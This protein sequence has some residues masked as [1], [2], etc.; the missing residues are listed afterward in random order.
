MSDPIYS[1]DVSLAT[2]TKVPNQFPTVPTVSKVAIIGEAPGATEETEGLPFVGAS[3]RLLNSLLSLVGMSR[4]QCFVGN[5]CQIRPPGNDIKHFDWDGDEIQ[6]GLEQLRRDLMQFDP[7]LIIVMGNA[8]LRAAKGIKGEVISNWRGSMF[9][10]PTFGRKC[11]AAY[12]PAYVLRDWSAFPL[13]LFDLKRAAKESKSRN[14]VLP[15]RFIEV[16]L[17]YW[18]VVDRINRINSGELTS[19]DIEGG[20]DGWTLMG[21]APRPEYAFIVDW[22][23]Y[24]EPLHYKLVAQALSRMLWRLDIPKIL[25]NSLY[26]NFVLAYGY[27]MLIRNV[28]EDTM[29]GGWEIYCEL[30]K[31]LGT[32]A[33]IYTM[34]PYYKV[35]HSVKAKKE[36]MTN[37]DAAKEYRVYCGKDSCTT[38]EIQQRQAEILSGPALEH[39]RFNMDLLHPLLYM[40]LR[41]INYA[42]EKAELL[43]AETQIE[44]NEYS[45]RL[46][47]R[48][49]Y[50]LVGPKGSLVS[51][52]MAK[53]LYQERGYPAQYKKEKGRLTDK[54]T[55]DVEALLTLMKKFPED[56][57]I[58][59]ILKHRKLESRLE[60]L[61]IGTDPDG[62][63]RCAYN[64]V[65]TETGRITC[66]GSPTGS[67]ANL[68]TITKKLRIL[69][70]ADPGYWLFQ[71]DLSG[72]DG[73]T[74]AARLKQLG[75][76][77][78]WDDYTA[79]LKP[80][81][82]IALMYAKGAEINKLSREE[83][84]QL[85]KAVDG[86][87]W[88]YFACKVVQHGTSYGMGEQT[89]STNIMKL[90]Y[91]HM[92]Q[93]FYVEPSECR[94]I[95][96]YFLARY[97]G[98]PLWHRQ[99]RDIVATKGKMT[100]ASGHTREF[101][102]RRGAQVDHALL[103]Q[104]LAE[105]PQANTTYATNLAM[106]RLWADPENRYLDK[107]GKVKLKIE[108]LH[109]VH[110]ALIGQ[111]RKEDTSWAVPRIKEYFNNILRIGTMDV[112][113]PFEGAYGPSWGEQTEGII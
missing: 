47:L 88:L 27:R 72:A 24:K 45:K 68:Q 113:I 58:H 46:E 78:M 1:L 5:V 59:E 77:T 111:F 39:Y 91:K 76:S 18:E 86:E 89:M 97:F 12:H 8:A 103:G 33:S 57:I 64:P 90:S 100:S 106:R 109:Q 50:S 34:E 101:F 7:D 63:V 95:Q 11:I 52:R 14:L 42:K 85:C 17:Q 28:Q 81:K 105:E 20:L 56:I 110:D 93:P 38:K 26:D 19:V 22:R 67:G 53:F 84:K 71:C 75:D 79:G 32:Q 96:G 49:G 108:P 30:P 73:W 2:R 83:L 66:Y 82:I 60:T 70:L 48:A 40:E 94:K 6:H 16:D 92:G 54:L 112:V 74:V 4:S 29:L 9:L 44:K 62:R 102:G 69:Y 98:M 36:R 99:V 21:I 87:G 51:Q 41:G 23:K 55:T 15:H 61:Q 3:G 35:S 104:A 43:L 31:D 65:G 25:Q 37:P 10:S 107:D 13:L 80:A